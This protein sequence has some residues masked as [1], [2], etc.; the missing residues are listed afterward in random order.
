MPYGLIAIALYMLFSKSFAQTQ[1][2]PKVSENTFNATVATGVGAYDGFFGPGTGTFFTLAY[3]KLRG[4]V[5]IEATAHAKLLNFTTNIFS[6]AIFIVS[7]QILWQIGLAMAL[8]QIVGS[9]L[10]AATVLK[11]GNE[12]IRYMTV[13]VCIAMSISLLIKS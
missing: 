9:R 6:L 10:G 8:G 12:L 5:L 11:K 3:S 13:A 7:G 1:Q 4:M 2:K